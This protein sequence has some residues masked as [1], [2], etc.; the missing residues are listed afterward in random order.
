MTYGRFAAPDSENI[1][2][3]SLKI[4]YERDELENKRKVAQTHLEN[5]MKF[6]DHSPLLIIKLILLK[7]ISHVS[8][9]CLKCLLMTDG[10]IQHNE[11]WIPSCTDIAWYELLL[12]LEWAKKLFLSWKKLGWE[13]D[14]RKWNLAKLRRELGIILRMK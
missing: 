8:S 3:A 6:F 11:C 7:P 4:R 5:T 13:I 10:K 1:S 12:E 14:D 2:L 9:E